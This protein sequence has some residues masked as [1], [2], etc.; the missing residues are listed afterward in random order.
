MEPSRV[1]FQG[2]GPFHLFV[3]QSA[4]AHASGSSVTV[5]LKAFLPDRGTDLE[6]A[7]FQVVPSQGRELAI[8]LLRACDE[9]DA[10]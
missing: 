2:P 9:V 7:S 6:A 4:T 1:V 3:A 5:T 10:H 8:S